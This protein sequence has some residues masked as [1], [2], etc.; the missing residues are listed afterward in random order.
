MQ[1]WH[2][3][4]ASRDR[5]HLWN[6]EHD[7]LRIVRHLAHLGGDS[8]V[9]FCVVDDHL[10]SFHHGPRR[11]VGQVASGITQTIATPTEPAFIKEVRGRS[12]RTW[13][14]RYILTQVLKHGIPGPPALWH[15]S[16][17]LDLIGAR[18]LDGFDRGTIERV[19]PRSRVDGIFTELGLAAEPIHALEDLEGIG[20]AE[21]VRAAGAS[22][23]CGRGAG[24]RQPHEVDARHLAAW[25]GRQL[26][27]PTGELGAEL[28]RST[29]TVRML[30]ARRPPDEHI[31]ALRTRLALERRVAELS[32][33]VTWSPK[34]NGGRPPGGSNSPT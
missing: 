4:L 3:T 27:L 7:L 17:F 24:T 33:Q 22:L 14:L 11:R 21:L 1:T 31:D 29:R 18:V 28:K 23:G 16:S 9:A 10:H 13:L 32:P 34:G 8:L 2:L 5:D 20:A 25:L 26:D 19:L 12:Y 6:D 30:A 15:G